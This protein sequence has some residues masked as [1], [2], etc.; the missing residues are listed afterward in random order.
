[1]REPEIDMKRTAI[2]VAFILAGVAALVLKSRY[3][4]PAEEFFH[5][6]GG[7]FVVSF[8]V[9]FLAT[10]PPPA[11]KLG[12]IA[13]ALAALLATEFFE[14]TDGFG[15]MSNTYDPY[16]LLANPAGILLALAVSSLVWRE[17]KK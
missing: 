8:A 7:N 13:P 12:K 6:Y 14:L 17:K 9:Y 11:L 10:L 16:D 4:G 5:S 1:M 3:H 2:T 15:F